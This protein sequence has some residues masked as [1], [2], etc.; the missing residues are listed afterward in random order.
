M[1]WG[2]TQAPDLGVSGVMCPSESSAHASRRAGAVSPPHHVSAAV[3]P[4]PRGISLG[5]R[6]HATRSQGIVHHSANASRP[7]LLGQ[8]VGNARSC[9]HSSDSFKGSV[10]GY[11]VELRS[12]QIK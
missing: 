10:I 3:R 9:M 4:T 5:P 11:E 12:S 8:Y 1:V 2:L 6:G 7:E